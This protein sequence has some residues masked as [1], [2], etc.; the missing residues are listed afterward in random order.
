[1]SGGFAMSFPSLTIEDQIVAAIRRIMR[2]VDLH[3]RQL[4]EACGLTGPQLAVLREAA[5]LGIA[6]P[7]ALARAV[8][9]SG[10]TVTG[11]VDRLVKR[12]LV[13]RARDDR[14]RRGV[15]VSV[16]A[17]GRELLAGAPSLLQDR[18]RQEL[19]RLADWERTNVLATLQRIAAMMDAELLDAAPV[20]V[21]GAV[22]AKSESDPGTASPAELPAAEADDDRA[23]VT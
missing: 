1:M 5:R 14:D 21:P 20:L 19:T 6:S 2:A 10:A 17:P 7:S 15:I 12:G 16:T 13:E 22:V 4:V 11:I 3:S 18:F 23:P 9:L 8:H